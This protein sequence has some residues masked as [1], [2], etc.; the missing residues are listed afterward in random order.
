MSRVELSGE[1]TFD[2]T[3]EATITSRTVPFGHR[4]RMSQLTVTTDSTTATSVAVYRNSA[5]PP[6]VVDAVAGAGNSNT[7]DVP[8]DL[9][10]GDRV[11]VQWTGGTAG[12]AARFT[13][14]GEEV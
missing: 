7:T 5:Q 9:V 6:N 8:I 4:W 3:G 14:T 13:A 1:A 10:A 12:T 11:V 2:S